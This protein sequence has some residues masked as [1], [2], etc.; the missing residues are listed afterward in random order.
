MNFEQCNAIYKAKVKQIAEDEHRK[1]GVLLARLGLDP[2]VLPKSNLDLFARETEKFAKETARWCALVSFGDSRGLKS[3]V[4]SAV[5][6]IDTD[7]RTAYEKMA[8]LQ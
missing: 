4:I 6:S 2:A 7:L 5:L 8:A 1:A 3:E